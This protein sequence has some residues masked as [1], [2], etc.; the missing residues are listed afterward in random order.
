MDISSIENDESQNNTS[1]L[2]DL[3]N[4]VDEF[5]LEVEHNHDLYQKY[6]RFYRYMKNDFFI[7]NQL[8]LYFLSII[9]NFIMLFFLK[10]DHVDNQSTTNIGQLYSR[11]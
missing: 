1:K 8:V 10:A 2:V 7:Q 6:Q 3:F 5:K 11:T 9:L 4:R